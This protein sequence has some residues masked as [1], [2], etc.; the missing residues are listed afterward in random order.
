MNMRHLAFVAALATLVGSA[1]SGR[2][3]PNDIV[4]TPAPAYEAAQLDRTDISLAS[5]KGQVVLLN[6]WATWCGPCRQEI[7]YLASLQDSDGPRGLRVIGISVDA[8]EDR[9]KVVQL[10]PTLG[11]TYD[12]WLDPTERIGGIIRSAAV[13]ATVLVDRAGVVRWKHTGV[14]REDTPGFREA[15]NAALTSD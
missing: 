15:M 7:P 1:C 13:P 5:L 11:I 8:A 2:S 12:V 9:E 10:A 6:V 4:G 3:E 14:I